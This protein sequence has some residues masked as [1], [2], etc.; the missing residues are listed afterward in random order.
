MFRAV[1]AILVDVVLGALLIILAVTHATLVFN[2]NGVGVAMHQ[3]KLVVLIVAIMAI[4][5]AW[6]LL[7][8]RRRKTP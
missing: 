8:R 3:Y 4:V 5:T 6:W 1:V 2:E 7:G